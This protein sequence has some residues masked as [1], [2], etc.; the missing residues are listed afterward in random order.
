MMAC[1]VGHSP[2][3]KHRSMENKRETDHHQPTTRLTS[4]TDTVRTEGLWWL[5]RRLQHRTPLSHSGGMLHRQIRRC[6]GLLLVAPRAI[7]RQWGKTEPVSTDALYAF[8]DLQV[9]PVTYDSSWFVAAAERMR[10]QKGM[11]GSILS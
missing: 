9:A 4:L 10:R 11:L 7:L 3:T 6:I 2:R 1:A 5:I 8:L